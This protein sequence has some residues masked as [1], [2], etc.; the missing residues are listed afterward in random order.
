MWPFLCFTGNILLAAALLVHVREARRTWEEQR[1]ARGRIEQRLDDHQTQLDN[2]ADRLTSVESRLGS[3][4]RQLRSMQQ[5]MGWHDEHAWTR[6]LE[7]KRPPDGGS[8]D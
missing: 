3:Y 2:H 8:A 1:L 4:F 5:E 6:K 7:R